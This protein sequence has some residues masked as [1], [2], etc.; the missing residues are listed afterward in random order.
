MFFYLFGYPIHNSLSPKL[1][2]FIFKTHNLD[3]RYFKFETYSLKD[4]FNYAIFKGASI[5]IPFKEKVIPYINILDQASQKIGAVNTILKQD[6]IIYGY[7][8]DWIGIV[9]PLKLINNK[10]WKD[11]K[12]L[13]LGAGGTARAAT[14]GMKFL[15]CHNIN[16][17]NRSIEKGV[18]LSLEFGCK[19]IQNL[20]QI[21]EIDIVISTI[22]ASIK[23]TLPLKIIELKPIIFDVNY[24][25]ETTALTQQGLDFQCKIIRGI[26]MLIYQGIEQNRIWTQCNGDFE[27]IKKHLITQ[28]GT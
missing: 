16:I 9:K 10:E 27:K 11:T 8:T 17:Y 24:Y 6:N 20:N 28:S 26:D 22:P 18:K 5:T 15:N 19:Y 14:Y 23:Y 7:N 12:V 1:H 2:N 13:I 21:D 25:P 3:H 4:I